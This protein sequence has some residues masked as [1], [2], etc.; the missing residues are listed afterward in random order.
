[1]RERQ[2]HWQ[3]VAAVLFSLLMASLLALGGDIVGMYLPSRFGDAD[4]TDAY[5]CGVLVGGVL[6]IG[7]GVALV[8]KLWPRALRKESP[9]ALKN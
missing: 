2:R 5:L 9:P 8:W 3:A 7:G 4:E 1:M 6:A